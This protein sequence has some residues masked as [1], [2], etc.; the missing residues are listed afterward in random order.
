MSTRA[1]EGGNCAPGLA[2]MSDRMTP[3][4]KIS[5]HSLHKT[6]VLESAPSPL[7]HVYPV[8]RSSISFTSKAVAVNLLLVRLEPLQRGMDTSAEGNYSRQTR[9]NLK[10]EQVL[11]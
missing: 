3:Q 5:S 1:L 7:A 4:V 10:Q 2:G 8:L 9:T 6:I 11:L